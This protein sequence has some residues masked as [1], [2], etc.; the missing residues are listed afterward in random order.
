MNKFYFI[1]LIVL[2]LSACSKDTCKDIDRGVYI[3]PEKPN[4]I[5]S[6]WEENITQFIS[7]SLGCIIRMT[8][9]YTLTPNFDCKSKLM[10]SLEITLQYGKKDNITW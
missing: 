5:T 9:I 6:F 10:L 2:L 4:G 3:Y 8:K 7:R 1:F